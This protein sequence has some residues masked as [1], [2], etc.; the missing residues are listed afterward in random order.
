MLLC[1]DEKIV[2]DAATIVPDAATIVPDAAPIVP[3]AATIVP[4]SA[5][6]VPDA[7]TIVPDAATIVPDAAP[8]VPDAT[9]YLYSPL[10]NFGAS[11]LTSLM[12]IVISTVVLDRSSVP[13][14]INQLLTNR[15]PKFFFKKC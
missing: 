8:I 14:Y 11:S 3:D 9:T 12:V 4:D 13:R 1:K 7:A 2:P 10:L 6:I 15:L 5:T